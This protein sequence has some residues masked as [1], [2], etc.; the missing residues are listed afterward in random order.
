VKTADQSPKL[1]IAI[2]A[3]LESLPSIIM[4]P[5]RHARFS[6]VSK[7]GESEWRPGLPG[8][9]AGINVIFIFKIGVIVK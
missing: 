2:V 5:A 9:Q 3:V 1:T 4:P 7:S 8:F 6:P